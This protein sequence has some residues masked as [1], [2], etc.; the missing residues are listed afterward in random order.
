MLLLYCKELFTM[1]E[2]LQCTTL[3]K[4]FFWLCINVWTV[5]L[6]LSIHCSILFNASVLCCCSGYGVTVGFIC[7]S[8]TIRTPQEFKWSRYFP[9]N[10]FPK[11]FLNNLQIQIYSD[12]LLWVLDVNNSIWTFPVSYNINT[13]NT[14]DTSPGA[15]MWL[16]LSHK[17]CSHL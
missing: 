16:S 2:T 3:I 15:L 9:F 6:P 10:Y 13:F 4:F 17:S 12:I 1:S 5:F 14:Q 8:V 11:F 7:F